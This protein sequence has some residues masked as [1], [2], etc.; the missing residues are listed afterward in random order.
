[1]SNNSELRAAELLEEYLGAVASGRV[2]S[3]GEL[4]KRCPVDQRES[5]RGAI[6]GALFARQNYEPLLVSE[7]LVD[8]TLSR[9]TAVRQRR[10]RAQEARRRLEQEPQRVL[11]AEEVLGFLESILG[12]TGSLSESVQGKTARAV[13]YR[14]G[15]VNRTTIA[16][17]RSA[18]AEARASKEAGLLLARF[19]NPEPP[20]DPRSIA[21]WLGVVIVEEEVEGCDGCVVME[22]DMAGILV[23]AAISSEG[24]K[25]FTVAHELGHFSL[26]KQK[27]S[28]R[29]ETL[30]EIENP[31]REMR[32]PTTQRMETEANAFAS[33]LL[34]PDD[35]V[36]AQY[37]RGVPSFEAIEEMASRY[38]V[39]MT[40]AAVRLVKLSDY[41]CA[42]VCTIEGRIRWVLRSG[43]WSD[44]FVPKDVAPPRDSQAGAI[45][46]GEAV[47]DEYEECVAALW[48]PDHRRDEDAE[49]L[50][51]SRRIYD[52]C[53]LTL[54]YDAT[55]EWQP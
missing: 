24:R 19:G 44:Y 16:A 8:E 36:V 21:E 10:E 30:H 49:L 35:S 3:V 32:D 4:L 26:H 53:I 12:L 27:I 11:G 42:L 18:V 1:M 39:S 34:M 5:L 51:H 43:E 25:R 55:A 52:D 23:N 14:G 37:A 41:A 2:S 54:L 40:A 9:V 17:V 28:F 46:A 29:R 31:L 22:N 45:L 48:A 13:M 15:A 20:I 7:E 47:E 38:L 6:E 50:E 33:E